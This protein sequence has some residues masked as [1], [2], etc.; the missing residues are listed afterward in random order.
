[1]NSTTYQKLT[2]LV[3]KRVTIAYSTSFSLGIKL[4]DRKFHEPIYNIYGFV[5]IA[6]EIVDTF[7]EEYREDMF[8]EFCD[9][10]WKALDRN[11]SPHLVLHSFVLTANK[12]QIPRNM[13]EDFLESMRLDL[14]K[15]T[16]DHQ[17]F[18]KYIYGSAEVVGLMCLVVFCEGNFELY[19]KLESSARHLGAAFQ[20]VNFLRDFKED[21]E[22]KGRLYFPNI[23]FQEF[24]PAQKESIEK[25]IDLDFEQALIGI[26]MLPRE[27]KKGVYIAYKYYYSLLKKIKK[28]E[29]AALQ[30]QRIRISNMQ[31]LIILLQE[32][33]LGRI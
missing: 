19:Q 11:F 30:S 14:N 31:K 16:Y 26:K 25:D 8:T 18:E 29:P 20:K 1:M 22:E 6:D 24:T 33:G 15:K 32:K 7:P 3:S 28:K 10:V 27:A 5:R 2:A 23:N 17:L 21:Y 12:Y 9:D 4:L 13:I